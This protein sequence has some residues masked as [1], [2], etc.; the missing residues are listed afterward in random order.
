[1]GQGKVIGLG[2]VMVLAVAGKGYA[3]DDIAVETFQNLGG[4]WWRYSYQVSYTVDG[5]AGSYSSLTEFAV[6]VLPGITISNVQSPNGWT[7][8]GETSPYTIEG[9]DEP[10]AGTYP[11]AIYWT[12]SGI[13]RN[14]SG[15]TGTFQFDA[16]APPGTTQWNT[17]EDGATSG[18]T[19]SGTLTG[20]VPEPSALALFGL[21][22]VGVAFLRRRGSTEKQP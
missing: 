10:A 12:H 20:P 17:E 7:Y 9:P 4:G 11:R 5:F 18:Y 8:E 6:V 15:Q 19:T 3:I 21:G 22:L 2:V 1:M 13:E 16:D 14:E